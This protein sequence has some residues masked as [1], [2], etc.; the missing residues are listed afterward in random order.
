MLQAEEK[1]IALNLR[2]RPLRLAYLVTC[3]EDIENAISLYTHTWGGAAN[4]ILPVYDDEEKIKQ[5]QKSLIKFDPDH[6]L[7]THERELSS[8]VKHILDNYPALNYSIHRK[9]I[10]S[11]V[12]Q[13]DNIYIRVGNLISFT[14]AKLPHIVSTLNSLYPNP[15]SNI[16]L[17]VVELFPS[18]F[19]LALSLQAGI[20]T[21]T[22]QQGLIRHLGANVLKTPLNCE[23]LFKISL[24]LSTALNP[25]LLTLENLRIE[26]RGTF[27]RSGWL[28]EPLAC[29]LYTSLLSHLKNGRLQVIFFINFANCS[30]AVIRLSKIKIK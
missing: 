27:H 14:Q 8:N 9:E 22:Y 2:S 4:A 19:D 23:D 20:I 21:Q 15:V 16:D 6:I 18:E 30:H 13:E 17:N 11:F 29:L 5:L 3:L 28:D 26:E 25:A 10:E 1:I 7:F 24:C 12:K